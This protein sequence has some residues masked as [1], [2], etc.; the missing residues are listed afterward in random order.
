MSKQS[1]A[2][3][4]PGI[5]IVVL[6]LPI[7]LSLACCLSSSPLPESTPEEPERAPSGDEVMAANCIAQGKPSDCYKQPPT[8]TWEWREDEGDAY[9]PATADASFSPV[10]WYGVRMGLDFVKNSHVTIGCSG[11]RPAVMFLLWPSPKWSSLEISRDGSSWTHPK[12]RKHGPFGSEIYKANGFDGYI[13]PGLPDVKS[14]VAS[15]ATQKL[16]YVRWRIEDGSDDV[17]YLATWNLSRWEEVADRAA[18]EC[19]GWPAP[20]WEGL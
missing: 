10:S 14:F 7:G 1:G 15:I 5:V 16:L 9:A 13:Y 2:S 6:A 12:L 3:P 11:G 17:S 8:S 4:L 18:W 19:D 20:W